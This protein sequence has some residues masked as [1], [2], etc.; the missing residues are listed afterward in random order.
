VSVDS[1]PGVSLEYMV[2][3]SG[4]YIID[5]KSTE[6]LRGTKSCWVR[7]STGRGKSYFNSYERKFVQSRK[8]IDGV[9]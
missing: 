9:K 1:I 2:Y 4:M 3:V 8:P 7:M 6:L 5:A